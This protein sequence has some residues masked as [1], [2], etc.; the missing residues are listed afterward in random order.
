MNSSSNGQVT[1]HLQGQSLQLLHDRAIYWPATRSL[2]V[3]DIHFGKSAAFR[4]HGLPIPEGD[5]Q[6]DLTR[7]TRLIRTLKAE[8]LL[9]AG[10]LLHAAAGKSD[11]VRSSVETWRTQHRE[12]SIVLVAGNHDRSAGTIPEEWKIEVCAESLATPPFVILHDPAAIPRTPE[13]FYICGHLHPAIALGEGGRLRSL[14]APCFWQSKHSLVLPGF[15]KFT[16]SV[17][18]RPALGDKIYAITETTVVQVP[19]PLLK[20]RRAR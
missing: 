11:S 7:L 18:I 10:D 9:I 1:I 17:A 4:R 8:R 20:M 13:A 15:G 5:T 12:L 2:I 19:E 6:G 16:G 3:A 14:K